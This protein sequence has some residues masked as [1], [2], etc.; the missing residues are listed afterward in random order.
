MSFRGRRAGRDGRSIEQR[1]EDGAPLEP[2]DGASGLVGRLRHHVRTW[3]A[4][5]VEMR[6][7]AR[8]DD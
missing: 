5:Y 3:P 1:G 6:L 7:N 4:R 8:T 2:T